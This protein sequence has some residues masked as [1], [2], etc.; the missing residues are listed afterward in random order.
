[1]NTEKMKLAATVRGNIWVYLTLAAGT[2]LSWLPLLGPNSLFA[3][4][5]MYVRVISHG[6][7]AGY[8]HSFGFWR[9]AGV[10]PQVWL[11]SKSPCYPPVVVLLAHLA[12]VFLFFHLC[13]MLF[14]GIKLPVAAALVFG[15]F[16]FAYEAQTWMIAYCYVVAV[17]FFLANLLLLANHTEIKWP[18][19]VF[20]C[21][22]SII[23]LFTALSNE[24]LFFATIFSGCFVW[25]RAP[26]GSLRVAAMLRGRGLLT[27]A[28]LV[29]CL[30][31]LVLYY[32]FKGADMQKQITVM[33]LPTVLGMWFKQRTLPEIFVPWASPICRHLIFSAWSWV[34]V[35]AVIACGVLF[36]VGLGCSS[37]VKEPNSS[38]NPSAFH[39][40][41][42]ILAIS[43][44]A[45]L[46]YVVG[47]GYST[48]CRK[49][50]P[51]VVLLLLFG[52][53]IY[54]ALFKRHRVS[55]SSFVAYASIVFGFAAMTT[56]LIVGIWKYETM[57]YNSLADF[58]TDHKL[59]GNIEIR[60]NPDVYK[61]W[62]QMTRSVGFRFDQDWVMNMAVDARGG[63]RVTN[64]PNS[65]TWVEYDPTNSRWVAGKN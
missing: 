53:W 50:Y 11:F 5:N 13:R 43:F 62:P 47:G 28:P 24:C 22:S 37:K 31:W 15:M 30:V 6:G 21:L 38:L 29:G 51:I 9:M 45:S 3:D 49:K 18:T 20:F 44:G 35:T 34:T 4:D 36:L 14:G 7:V 55:S 54:R 2:L 48:D 52:C 59:R 1:M 32:S 65:S 57:R 25:I 23:A 17:V 42:A 40:L 8:I 58:V 10:I 64:S 60:W 39:T 56:W 19:P 63:D 26:K 16:P 46:I 41:A 12:A 27:W 61:A 33:H